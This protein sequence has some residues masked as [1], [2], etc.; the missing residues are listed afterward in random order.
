MKDKIIK[1]VFGES[2][3]QFKDD[4]VKKQL[5]SL[6]K[7]SKILDAGAGELR[8]KQYCQHLQYISQDFGEYGGDRL[9]CNLILGMHQGM[10]LLVI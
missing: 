8:W 1:W 6:D 10:I 9:D 7:G 3:V 4:W 2:S 5:L